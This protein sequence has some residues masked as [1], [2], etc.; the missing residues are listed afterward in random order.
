MPSAK[1]IQLNDDTAFLLIGDG[2][3]HKSWFIGT[4]PSPIYVF[5]FDKGMDIHAGRSDIDYDTFKE[6]QRGQ[7]LEKENSVL[8]AQGHYEYG[9]AWPAFLKKLNDLG[10]QIDR[11][12]CPYKTIAVDSL[13][14]AAECCMS[15]VLNEN[16]RTATEQRDWQTFG[17]NMKV[18]FSQLTGWPL[19]KVLT[20]HIKRDENLV[21]GAIE[22][23]PLISGQ[24]AGVVPVFFPE[25]YYTE[26]NT[27]TENGKR[28]TSFTFRCQ[29]D[30]VHKQAKSRKFFLTDG[31][32][33]DYREIMKV[34]AARTK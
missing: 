10:Q 24:S 11:G 3:T 7:K 34:V 33:T 22:K 8:A 13:T 28:I 25:V 26:A 19:T 32:P 5:D 17:S 20:A 15:Y 6:L 4:C 27:K 29:Q 18:L 1:D 30:N 23:L 9:K 31:L 12:Q 16:N 21:T 14:L 2:G